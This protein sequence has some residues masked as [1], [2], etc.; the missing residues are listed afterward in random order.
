MAVMQLSNTKIG[1]KGAII[2]I[3][4]TSALR[5]RLMDLGIVKGAEIEMVRSAP[6]GDPIEFLLRGYNLMLRREEAEH[7]WLEVEE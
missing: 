6:L 2:R 7:V 1:D 5:R 3:G 4:G